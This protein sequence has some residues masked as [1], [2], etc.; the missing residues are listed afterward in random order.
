MNKGKSKTKTKGIYMRGNIFW[1]CYSGPDGRM[2][3]ESSRSTRKTDAVNLLTKRRND[4][5]EGKTAAKRIRT[6]I[7]NDLSEKYKHFCSG[8][9]GFQQKSSI[10][11]QLENR[12]GNYPLQAFNLLLMEQ[13]QAERR[14]KG[15]SNSTINRHI[16]TIKHMMKKAVDWRM[17]GRETL[18]DVRSV[19]MLPEENEQLRFLSKVEW[20]RILK[21]SPT[22][23][24][25]IIIMAAYT[26]MR[27]GE[28][29]SLKW[30]QIDL[31]HR[32]IFLG[33]TKS[34][35]KKE[36]PIIDSLVRVL[37]S[38]P[39]HIFSDH[40]F[41][42]PKTGKPFKDIKKSWHTTLK[43]AKIE[44]FRFHDLRH[45]FASHLRMAGKTL[46]DIGEL[47]GHGSAAMTSRYAHLDIKYKL[48]AI[49]SLEETLPIEEASET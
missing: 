42:N 17:V 12:F 41:V 2:V 20:K 40:V 47:L 49:K 5:L 44:N 11:F 46:D 15:N 8:Q 16:A 13:Y 27:R 22:H 6:H 21:N 29:L 30:S 4:V 43:K 31:Q 3:W 32:L 38:V 33:K 7:F 25:P 37:S 23:L 36:I 14:E 28:I 34:G 9:K 48:D 10:I 18:Y 1:I 45:T 19:Q 39:R 24:R 26:G 35:R